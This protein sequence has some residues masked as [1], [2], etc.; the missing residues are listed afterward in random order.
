MALHEDQQLRFQCMPNHLI[1]IIIIIINNN[2]NNNKGRNYE[3][4]TIPCDR[5][6]RDERTPSEE[7]RPGDGF[8]YLFLEPERLPVW[9]PYVL[10]LLL[11]N[12]FVH[13]RKPTLTQSN[14]N[15]QQLRYQVTRNDMMMMATRRLMSLLGL[16]LW[17]L[18]TL[19]ATHGFVVVVRP[20]TPWTGI[21]SSSSKTIGGSGNNGNNWE[22]RVS[23][24]V[25]RTTA[26][27]MSNNSNSNSKK[28][29]AA[30]TDGG[31]RG[32]VLFIIVMLVNVWLFSIPPY[33]RRVLICPDPLPPGCETT[34]PRIKCQECITAEE[35]KQGVVEYY[36]NGGG[37]QFDFSINPATLEAN[38]KALQ[39][40][41][42]EQTRNRTKQ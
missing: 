27:S 13:G 6:R 32:L 11:C 39:G 8:L 42:G 26:L 21:G 19:S 28:P 4:H 18:A 25:A 37:I 17:V 7:K 30:K 20:V 38:K 5:T 2:N 29:K 40:V 34:A 9:K 41:L 15:T 12:G 23:P 16:F 14:Y 1:I 22:W 36:Q 35:W 3:Y 33:F 24:M 10:L 31:D